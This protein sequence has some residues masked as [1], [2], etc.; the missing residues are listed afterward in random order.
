LPFVHTE[1][2]PELFGCGAAV[3]QKTVNLLVVGSN[4]TTRA[5][6]WYCILPMIVA[7]KSLGWHPVEPNTYGEVPERPKGAV[8]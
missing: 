5:N 2:I 8:C 7:V 3:A 6:T 4:P 1:F